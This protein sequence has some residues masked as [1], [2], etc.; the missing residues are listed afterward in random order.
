ME[1]PIAFIKGLPQQFMGWGKDMI[2]G[3]IDGITG[4]IG[5]VAG[6]IGSV[7]DKIASIIHF[8]R[9]D[10]GPLRNYEQWMPDF[11]G[12]LAAACIRATCGR[13]RMLCSP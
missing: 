1:Q 3:L 7:A 10:E 9:P 2:Q 12:G 13:W 6:A 11:M 8:S 4:M 5:N